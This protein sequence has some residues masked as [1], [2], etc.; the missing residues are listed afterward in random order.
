MDESNHHAPVPG[1]CCSERLERVH[2]D[3]LVP[4]VIF[5][6]NLPPST[7]DAANDVEDCNNSK[8]LEFICR[9]PSCGALLPAET[10]VVKHDNEEE[11]EEVPVD[12]NFFDPDYTL[13]GR[14]GFQVWTGTRIMIE[15]LLWKDDQKYANKRIRYW[16]ECIRDGGTTNILELGAGVG[17]VGCCL[18][19]AGGHVL[20]T[21][22]PTLVENSVKANLERNKSQ[23]SNDENAT[24]AT[25]STCPAWLKWQGDN[26][27]RI[28]KGWAAT[29]AINW[30]EPLLDQQ[31]AVEQCQ[32]IDLIIASDCVFLVE[33]LEAL[34]ATAATIFAQAQHNR[35][36]RRPPSLMIS[37]QRRDSKD[38]DNSKSFTTVNRV[39]AEVKAR[40]WSIDCLAWYPVVVGQDTSQVFVFE[41]LPDAATA[42]TA[43]SASS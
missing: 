11:E 26:A 41:I 3:D 27:V 24:T 9:A 42:T 14:T 1:F 37:F 5:T 4:S 38:G 34:L 40:N 7:S 28:G 18:A 19:A 30:K 29:T 21:D 16:Q 33:M 6:C 20:L 25:T 17:V 23:A 31:L 12:A 22:L 15:T 36:N 43:A 8:T 2:E 13:A 32:S 39:I 10:A 35:G